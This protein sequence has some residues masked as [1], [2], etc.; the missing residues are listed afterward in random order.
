MILSEYFFNKHSIA[1]FTDS[2]F[3]KK[4]SPKGRAIGAVA[5]A[6]IAY[7]RDRPIEYG[8]NIM[9][10]TTSQVGELNAILVGVMMAY[11]YQLQGYTVR[12]FSDSLNSILAVRDRIFDWV[13]KDSISIGPSKYMGNN[14]TVK[15]QEHIM[16]IIYEI[17]SNNM[18]IDF[19]HVKGHVNTYNL[20]SIVDAVDIF[21]R[22]NNFLIDLDTAAVISNRN[23]EVDQYSTDMLNK[24]HMDPK[25]DMSGLTP[26][27]TIGYAPFDMGKYFNL[28]NYKNAVKFTPKENY[29]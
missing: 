9:N 19:Y 18:P 29:G 14:G 17:L 22:H 21:R 4:D 28:V 12:I 20:N 24:N 6:A 8:F 15:N 10:H 5:P 3:K 2:S 7:W 1:I 11:K 26:G 27:I 13:Y 16:N 23:N 25:Y